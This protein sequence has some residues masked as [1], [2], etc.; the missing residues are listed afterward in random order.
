M[1][2]STHTHTHTHTH[3]HLPHPQ[4]LRLG[5]GLIEGAERIITKRNGTFGLAG[6]TAYRV[7]WYAKGVQYASDMVHGTKV[8]VNVPLNHAVIIE[9]A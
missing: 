8:R 7:Y 1:N 2:I 9:S 3:A 6:S 5:P 4:V